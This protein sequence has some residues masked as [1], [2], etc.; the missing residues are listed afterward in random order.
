[1]VRVARSLIIE[2]VDPCET[3][4]P[5]QIMLKI[6]AK[7]RRLVIAVKISTSIGGNNTIHEALSIKLPCYFVVIF[8]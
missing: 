3:I 2:K 1:M 8:F 6:K 7:L 4:Q 5:A